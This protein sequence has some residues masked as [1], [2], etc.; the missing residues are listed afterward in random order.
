LIRQTIFISI[1]PEFVAEPYYQ[2]HSSQSHSKTAQ[3]I[4]LKLLS[5][6]KKLALFSWDIFVFLVSKNKKLLSQKQ[7]KLIQFISLFTSF[8][9]IKYSSQN[10]NDFLTTSKAISILEEQIK[11]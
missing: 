2:S 7:N 5:F 4:Q 11:F 10:I 3:S 1:L 8:F 6:F 9:C